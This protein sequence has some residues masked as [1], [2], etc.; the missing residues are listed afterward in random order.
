MGLL[1]I[2]LAH[3]LVLTICLWGIFSHYSSLCILEPLPILWSSKHQHIHSL[4]PKGPFRTPGVKVLP[5]PSSYLPTPRLLYHFVCW[6]RAF[7]RISS[8]DRGKIGVFFE[9]SEQDAYTENLS[10][11]LFLS[12]LAATDW[13]RKHP[14][15]YKE[16]LFISSLHTIFLCIFWGGIL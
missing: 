2:F 7:A 16:L 10:P 13:K 3:T 1:N 6:Q 12:C 14:I 15:T 5:H 4:R 11:W 9:P 8:S